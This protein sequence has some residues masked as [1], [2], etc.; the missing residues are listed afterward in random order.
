M[1][2]AVVICS[3]SLKAMCS[4]ELEKCGSVAMA[5]LAHSLSLLRLTLSANKYMQP[6]AL[7]ILYQ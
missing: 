1:L 5:V 7:A 2:I 6:L 3:Y 4:L